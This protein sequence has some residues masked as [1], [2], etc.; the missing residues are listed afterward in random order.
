M[1]EGTQSKRALAIV[2]AIAA[3]VGLVVAAFGPRWLADPDHSS[4]GS[5]SRRYEECLP[6]RPA[7]PARCPTAR[8]DRQGD[9]R[10]KCATRRCLRASSR[11]A[12]EAVA[13]LPGRRNDAFVGCLVAA[14]GLVWAESSRS[15][16]S[17]PWS[18]GHADD[19]RGARFILRDRRLAA[20]SS[21]PSRRRPVDGGRLD[22]SH[23]RWR[24]RPRPRRGVPAQPVD[25]ADRP[26]S[27]VRPLRRCRG[28]RILD[29][30]RSVGL[31]TASWHAPRI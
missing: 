16:V 19:A 6:R 8:Q 10:D 26:T 28:A 5:A 30:Q 2:L 24:G 9:R 29:D 20:C 14:G 11:G 17:G 27:S 7:S 12:E 4:S 1:Q 15:P 13:R 3:A 18:A 21:R 22:V 25:P 23:V 31:A